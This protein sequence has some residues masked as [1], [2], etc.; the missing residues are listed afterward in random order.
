MRRAAEQLAAATALWRGEPLAGL[1]RDAFD[2]TERERLGELRLQALEL[3]LD[4]ELALGGHDTLVPELEALVRANPYRE[5]LHAQLM[6]AL[7]RSDRQ[8]DA[9]DAFQS[10]RHSLSE[11]LG[12]DPSPRLRELERAILRHDPS[13]RAVEPPPPSRLPASTTAHPPVRSPARGRRGVLA[14]P[15]AR[16]PDADADR[17]GRCRQDEARAGSG[18]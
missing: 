3:R 9:L 1:D 14:A 4:A 15:R 10:A 16:N 6:L 11:E 8:A 7:Y 2:E 13:L 12:I 17:A 18:A 5:R